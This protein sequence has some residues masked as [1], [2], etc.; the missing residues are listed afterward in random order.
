MANQLP[1]NG[2]ILGLDI[3]SKRIGAALASVIAKLPQPIEMIEM[4]EG[5]TSEIKRIINRE[6]ITLVVVG[7]PRSLQGEETSQSATIRQFADRLAENIETPLTY[8]DESLS[9]KR[10]DELMKAASFKNASRDSLA[11]CFILEEFFATMDR[12]EQL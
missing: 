8:V 10:S 7:V 5:A 3:G 2:Y 9:S 6:D 12:T 4:S 1:N 11:A